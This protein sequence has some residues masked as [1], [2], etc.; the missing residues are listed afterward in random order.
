MADKNPV[1]YAEQTLGVH[2]LWEDAQERFEK[3]EEALL[4]KANLQTGL[5]KLRDVQANREMEILQEGKAKYAEISATAFDK[6]YKTLIHEDSDHRELREN[7]RSC[8]CDLDIVEAEISAH[9]Y[10]LKLMNSRLQELGGLLNF[11]AS[12]KRGQ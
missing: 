3:Y 5:R 2:K 11:Y 4:H 1:A 10:Q 9:E 6:I 7:E 8:Q 12:A